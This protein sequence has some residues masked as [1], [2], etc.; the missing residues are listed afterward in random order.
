M[1]KEIRSLVDEM[2][3]GVEIAEAL[4]ESRALDAASMRAF[5]AQQRDCLKRIEAAASDPASWVARVP[6]KTLE[7][8]A[9]EARAAAVFGR[10]ALR[11]VEGGRP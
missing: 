1:S 8:I 6:V 10:P 2:M 7:E 11:V 4:Y 3:D 9:A 5:I